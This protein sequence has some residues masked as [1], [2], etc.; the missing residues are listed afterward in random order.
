[1]KEQIDEILANLMEWTRTPVVIAC[2]SAACLILFF[3]AA[4]R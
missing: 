2:L 4:V 1:M 3:I